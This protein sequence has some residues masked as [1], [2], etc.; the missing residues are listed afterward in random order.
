MIIDISHPSAA[1]IKLYDFNGNLLC[2]VFSVNTET[3]IG[4]Q[5]IC[6]NEYGESV[7]RQIEIYQIIAPGVFFERIMN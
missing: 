5:F 6:F 1:K 4:N 7:F 2:R 3:M